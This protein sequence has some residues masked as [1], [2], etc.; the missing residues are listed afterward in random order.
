[1]ANSNQ[2]GLAIWEE[3]TFGTLPTGGGD[4]L[5][6]VRFTSESLS[7]RTSSSISQELRTDRQIADI[8]RT[9]IGAGGSIEGEFSYGS[10]AGVS[11]AQDLL[12]EAALQSVDW[13][14]AVTNAGTYSG[15][16]NSITGTNVSVGI[17]A[18]RWVRFKDGATLVGYFLVTAVPDANTL[19]VTPAVSGTITGGGNE[20]IEAGGYV[21]NG[22]TDRSFSIE[23]SHS[24]SGMSAV[25]EQYAGMKVE[26]WAVNFAA[27]QIS[28]QSFGLLGKTE[29]SAAATMGD[30]ANTAHVTNDVMNGVDNVYAIRENHTSLG[31][32]VRSVGVSV[33]NNLFAREAVAN[34]GPISMGSGSFNAAGS[35]T[36]YFEDNTLLDK[37]RNWTTTSLTLVLQDAT[38]NAYC[39]YLPKVKLSEASATTPGLN[40]DVTATFAFQ[41]FRDS[42]NNEMIRVTRWDA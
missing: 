35:L 32:I 16:A 22:I 37:Y 20:E 15:S 39:I 26:S 5:K 7:K 9:S 24:D 21:K 1:M 13:V 40:Q 30:G 17:T 8:V 19:T 27:A 41:A 33:T 12:I 25:F 29:T 6:S 10:A 31:T 14:A 34:L 28:Q 18:G 2:V 38:G 42:T 3:S 23:R 36:V 11:S 4:D